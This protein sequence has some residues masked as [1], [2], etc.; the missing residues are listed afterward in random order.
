[1]SVGIHRFSRRFNDALVEMAMID[2]MV[3]VD[4]WQGIDECLAIKPNALRKFATY[5]EAILPVIRKFKQR[6]KQN[7]EPQN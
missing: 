4:H 2:A 1:M 7:F 5:A 3:R 6:S